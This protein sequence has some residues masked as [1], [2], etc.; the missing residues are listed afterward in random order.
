MN[1]IDEATRLQIMRLLADNPELTQRE[2][3]GALGISLGATHYC[4][5][6]LIRKGLVKADNFRHSSNRRRYAYFLTPTGL[7]E[8]VRATR[9]FLERKQAE[10]EVLRQEI[11]RL[12]RELGEDTC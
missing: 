2:L 3:A 7:A 1:S 5:R 9:A 4:L 6:A 8:K 12:R 11:A 10:H